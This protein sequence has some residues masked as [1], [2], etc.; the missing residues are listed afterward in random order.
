MNAADTPITESQF[1]PKLKIYFF[2]SGALA[3][4]ITVVGIVLLPIWL[5]VGKWWAQRYYDALRLE[6]T[7]RNVIIKKGV[8]FRKELTIP[9]DKIQDISIHEGP[10]LKALGLL[11]LRIETAGQRNSGTG[12]SDADLTGLLD[13]RGMRDRI[14]SLRDAQVQAPVAVTAH[15][16]QG[17][18]TTVS[19]LR[20]IRD[21]LHR[22]ETGM[23]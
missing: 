18:E 2:L 1:S 3:L 16:D 4:S 21:S 10:L 5:F 8:W 9:L 12:Q 7:N 19:L 13:A 23:R 22:I 6:V 17:D 15:T 14:L 11:S 20:E